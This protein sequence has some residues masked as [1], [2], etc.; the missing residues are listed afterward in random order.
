MHHLETAILESFKKAEGKELITS[1]VVKLIFP[2]EFSIYETSQAKNTFFIGSEKG[3]THKIRYQKAILHKRLLYHLNKLVT[4][5]I[6]KVSG[7]EEHGEKRFAMVEN[8]GDVIIGDKKKTIVISNN[9]N[10]STPIDGYEAKRIIK[11]FNSKNWISK[12]D[13]VLLNATKFS[14]Y[15]ELHESIVALFEEVGDSIAINHFEEMVQNSANGDLKYFIETLCEEV[16]DYG[17]NINLL[18]DLEKIFDEEKI[19]SFI[20]II[21]NNLRKNII[22]IYQFTSASLIENRDLILYLVNEYAT[23][24]IKINIMNKSIHK[25]P[26]FVGRA[27]VYSFDEKEWNFFEKEYEKKQKV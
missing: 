12:L 27:G 1:D 6:L 11:K 10:P 3:A 5:G 13:A 15:Q 8:Y 18:I 21:I 22:I 2:D 20:D 26:V 14:D 4:E 24:R 25:S 17:K 23:H 19:K 7:I 9:F 16:N